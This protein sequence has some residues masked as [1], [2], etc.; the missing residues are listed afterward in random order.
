[1]LSIFVVGI[2]IWQFRMTNSFKQDN[3]R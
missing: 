3:N 2:A 1:L